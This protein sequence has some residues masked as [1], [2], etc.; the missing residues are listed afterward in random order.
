MWV[1]G[2]ETPVVIDDYLPTK[3]DKP[4]FAQAKSG[5]LWVCLLEKAW[6]KIFGSYGACASGE[7]LWAA[8]HLT[9]LPSFAIQHVSEKVASNMEK[10]WTKIQTCD[11]LGYSLMCGSNGRGEGKTSTGIIQGHAYSILSVHDVNVSGQSHRLL[12]LRNPW[13]KSE[14]NG[15]WSDTSPVWTPELRKQLGMEASGDDGMFMMPV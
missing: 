1:N 5:D 14:W 15:L 9:G 13:G 10:F 6:A 7:C 2:L 12:K 11:K 4:A 8:E 3:Y